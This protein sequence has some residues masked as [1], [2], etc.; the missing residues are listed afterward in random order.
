MSASLLC[1]FDLHSLTLS[2]R[3]CNAPEKLKNLPQ[4][5]G[6]QWEDTVEGLASLLSILL[7]SGLDLADSEALIRQ[8]C[9]E[10][11]PGDGKADHKPLPC[12]VEGHRVFR[13][14]KGVSDHVAFGVTQG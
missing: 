10:A 11:P 13:A 9:S 1:P 12:S 5:S 6:Q 14:V 3:M 4:V 2:L 8:A 7:Q